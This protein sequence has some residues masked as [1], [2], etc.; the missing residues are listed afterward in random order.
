MKIQPRAIQAF[1]HKPDPNIAAVLIYGP[2]SGLVSQRCKTLGMAIVDDLSDPFS[3]LDISSASLIEDPARL[4]D[5]ARAISFGG[6][7]RL[8]QL[9]G[10][11]EALSKIL[12]GYLDNPAPSIS[13]N[14]G[15]MIIV[16][17][18]ELTPRSSL[19]K[20]FE[21]HERAAA[22]A[23]YPLEGQELA[24]TCKTILN[25]HGVSIDQAALQSLCQ[26]LGNNHGV[27]RSE[28]EKLV[29]YVGDKKSVE[30]QDITDC[31]ADIAETSLDQLAFSVGDGNTP[32]ADTYYRKAM[33]EGTSEI[34][35][36]R[37]LQKHF[38]RLDW[39]TGQIGQGKNTGSIIAGLR[40]P[41][42]FKHRDRLENQTRRWSAEKIHH[43]LNILTHAEIA[44]KSTGTPTQLVCGRAIIA[45]GRSVK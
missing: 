29:L 27:M 28:L 39:I 23:S 31:L 18:L 4:N 17:C 34:A 21:G 24:N 38:Q 26:A 40:P 16:D 12:T 8:I 11:T 5:E 22:I 35:I 30:P 19:R 1:L 45:I 15:T 13:S 2:D 43:A 20:L 10:A 25:E 3:V 33:A 9:R 42:F 14:A 32:L 41:V 36:L 44:C 6:S 7:N 37:T